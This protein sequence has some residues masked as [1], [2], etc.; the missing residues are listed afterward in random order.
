VTAAF[1]RTFLALVLVSAMTLVGSTASRRVEA[2]EIPEFTAPV[3]DVAGVIPPSVEQRLDAT[4]LDYQRRSGNQI[5]VAVVRTTGD[6][7]LEDYTIDLAREWGV[8]TEGRD[9]GVLLLLATRDR[10]VRV[11]V[12]RALEGRLTDLESGRVIERMTPA[13]RAGRYGAAVEQGTER[14]RAALGDRGGGAAAT[15]G[16]V[17]EEPSR[18]AS[19]FALVPA[20]LILLL[21]FSVFGRRRRRRRWS[22]LGAPI[23]WG[24]ALGGFGGLGGGGFGGG[25]GLGGGG[26]GGGGGGDFGGGGASGGW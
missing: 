6:A 8:G 22:G 12:G 3:V 18:G 21:L 11:E 7:S 23:L 20:L 16:P 14:I 25:G 2:A 15:A 5:A 9:N 19:V 1:A 24:G 26:F 17:R 13:L 10:R 4:L